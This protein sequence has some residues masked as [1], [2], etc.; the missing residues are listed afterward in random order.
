MKHKKLITTTKPKPIV[1]KL[2]DTCRVRL[3][4]ELIIKI[5]ETKDI[6][7]AHY[8]SLYLDQ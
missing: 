5:L 1:I 6:T 8:N 7:E 3:E 4:H 2:Q